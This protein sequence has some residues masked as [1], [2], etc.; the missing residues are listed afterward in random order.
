MKVTFANTPDPK[1]FNASILPKDRPE[2]LDY[3]P[4]FAILNFLA[5]QY[6][7]YTNL[8]IIGNGGSVNN[9]KAIYNALRDEAKKQVY[10]VNTIDP[11]YIFWLKNNLPKSETL[12][13][14]ISKSGENVSQVEA[15][16][17]FVDFPMVFLAGV[18]S[19]VEALGKALGAEVISHPQGIGGRF[20]GLTEVG[21]LPASLCGINVHELY[22]GA[23]EVYTE[24]NQDNIS[25]KAASVFAQLEEK[26]YVD[27]FVPIYSHY[28]LHVG[29]L[30]TQLCHESFGKGGLGQTYLT[31]EAPES[32]HHTN[33]RFFGGRNNIAGLFIGLEQFNASVVTQVPDSAKDVALRK[34]PLSVLNGISLANAMRYEMEGTWENAKN[35][36]IPLAQILLEKP[37]PKEIGKL[38]AF[39]QLFAVYSSLERGVDPFNQPEVESSKTIGFNKR[40]TSKT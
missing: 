3:A 5:E 4:N 20:A 37:S 14:S 29:D 27:V 19:P 12:V 22:A 36:K 7:A 32:Q 2:F 39:W 9:F 18:G 35:S 13:L 11:D 26:G 33:Q 23:A 38:L 17:Q 28:L 15:T 31:T 16:L 34:Q 40:I 30:I 8:V 24:Y 6:S 10:F 25:Y 21:L 1:Q